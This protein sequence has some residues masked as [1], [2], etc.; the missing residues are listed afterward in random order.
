MGLRGEQR[1]AAMCSGI[2]SMS[3]HST[4][5]VSQYASDAK[6]PPN[7][8]SATAILYSSHPPF[9]LKSSYILLRT[10]FLSYSKIKQKRKR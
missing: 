1:R 9:A 6:L 2:S 7:W 4:C 5:V 8:V 10:P 3:D